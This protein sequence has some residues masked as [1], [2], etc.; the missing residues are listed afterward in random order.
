MITLKTLSQATA[1]EV[2]QQAKNHLL[3]QNQ[4]SLLILKTG[5]ETCAYRG[6][7]GLKSVAVRFSLLFSVRRSRRDSVRDLVWGSVCVSVRN[8]V[9]TPLT[10]KIN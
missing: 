3:T 2:F 10:N 5:K 6:D 7:N 9:M 4:V 8:S 1:M